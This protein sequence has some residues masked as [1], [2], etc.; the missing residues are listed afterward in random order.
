[1][2][3]LKTALLRKIHEMVSLQFLR[4]NSS[5]IAIAP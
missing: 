1:L 4:K 2:T 5:K 3:Y